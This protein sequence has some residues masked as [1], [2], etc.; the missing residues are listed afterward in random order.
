VLPPT[1]RELILVQ[2]LT[3][4]SAV[5]D[6]AGA[7][8]EARKI[9]PAAL[10][11]ARLYPDMFPL[12]RQVREAT[13][14]A[15]NACGRLA[16]AELL[17]FANTEASTPDLKERIAK[18]NA[19]GRSIDGML[20]EFVVLVEEG[21]VMIPAHLSA[22]ESATLPCAGVT[23]WHALVEH[24][25]LIAG[26]TV[27]LQGPG[28]VSTFGLQLAHAIGVQVVITSLSDEKLARAKNLG[29]NRGINYKSTPDWEK[30]AMEFT[31]GLAFESSR[32]GRFRKKLPP[33]R[34]CF[35]VRM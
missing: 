19:L 34:T 1:I 29:A 16:G 32:D 8:A 31:G 26:Q 25:K 33:T 9:D 17:T 20:A 30:A 23:A 35:M 21:V 27:L 15:A 7:H 10:L 6:K 18:T 22:K 12:V 24:G 2:F 4:L 5:L 28:G 11:N 13:S 3:S 14:H